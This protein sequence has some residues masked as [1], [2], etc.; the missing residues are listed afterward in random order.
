MMRDHDERS[1]SLVE[2]SDAYNTVGNNDSDERWERLIEPFH[3]EIR[4]RFANVLRRL[5]GI[6]LFEMTNSRDNVAL[7]IHVHDSKFSPDGVLAD[8]H[9]LNPENV[10]RKFMA[11]YERH[12][13]AEKILYGN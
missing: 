8:V 1:G 3:R 4:T 9:L 5:D 13:K 2:F 11:D 10:H 6:H 7:G 12:L